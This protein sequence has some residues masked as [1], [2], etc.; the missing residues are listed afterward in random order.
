MHEV[1][2]QPG[3]PTIQPGPMMHLPGS[4]LLAA[5]QPSDEMCSARLALSRGSGM[6]RIASKEALDWQHSSSFVTRLQILL[7]AQLET[8]STYQPAW[9]LLDGCKNHVYFGQH[10]VSHAHAPG[11]LDCGNQ[12]SL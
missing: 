6:Q 12:H 11:R 1:L 5:L 3:R 7:D 4:S 8:F 10:L 9:Q 2:P